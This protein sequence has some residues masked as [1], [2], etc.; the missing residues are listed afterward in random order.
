MRI[1]SSILHN[2]AGLAGAAAIQLWMR[3]MDAK[4]A[5]YDPAVDPTRREHQGGQGVYVFWH[6]YL[7]FPAYMRGHCN[8]TMLVSQHR[9]AEILARAARHLGMSF[10]RGSSTRGGAKALRSL[11]AHSQRMNL[12]ITPDGP[13]GPRRELA[14]G[15]VYLASRLGLPL[16]CIG[17]GY[18]RPWRFNSWDRFALPRLFSR[19]RAI[20]GPQL[21]LPEDLDRDGIEHYRQQVER[22]LNRLTAEAEQWAESGARKPEGVPL[23]REQARGHLRSDS[24]CPPLAGGP[25]ALGK[26][27]TV[28]ER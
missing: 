26:N 12:V 18:D 16:V 1:N 27:A 25:H 3:T 15:A 11:M 21:P 22:L 10:V 5:Y 20:V 4:V 28:A 14:Q 13:R 19:C 17:I 9:D 23:L 6:E 7:L 8:L 2:L 24:A